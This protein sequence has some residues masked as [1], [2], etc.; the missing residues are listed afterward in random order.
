[1]YTSTHASKQGRH[2]PVEDIAEGV[3]VVIQL[4]A[5]RVA[6]VYALLGDA[7]NL[8]A[9]PVCGFCDGE[10]VVEEGGVRSLWWLVLVMVMGWLNGG[11]GFV[12]IRTHTY[13]C[14]C[15]YTGGEGIYVCMCIYTQGK[16]E[17]KDVQRLPL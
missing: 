5:H 10:C 6:R 1:M 12:C 9:L 16:R 3:R 11:E 7:R 8:P 2:A 13:M 17:G 14:V 4:H 15:V